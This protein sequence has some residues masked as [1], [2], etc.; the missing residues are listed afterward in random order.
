MTEHL[1]LDA[2]RQSFA[3]LEQAVAGLTREELGYKPSPVKWSVT[4]VLAHLTDHYLVVSFRIRE[5]LSRS[6]VRLPAF[7]QDEWVEGQHAADGD[8]TDYL[9]LFGALHAFHT[10]LFERL[11]P[12]AWTLDGIN[13]KGERVSLEAI[14]AAFS[15]HLKLHLAQIGRTRELARAALAATSGQTAARGGG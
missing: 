3:L 1:H 14:I 15:A 8:A 5:V 7:R 6:A 2:Y 10:R 13:A 4:E 11:A 9:A 12:E